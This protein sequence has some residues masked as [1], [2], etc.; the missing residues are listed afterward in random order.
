MHCGDGR[1][2]LTLAHAEPQQ[3]VLPLFLEGARLNLQ[4][5]E[6]CLEWAA[7]VE[8]LPHYGDSARG[9]AGHS[10]G[11]ARVP[12]PGHRLPFGVV[13]DSAQLRVRQRDELLGWQKQVQNGRNGAC[14]GL[15]D[16]TPLPF[17]HKVSDHVGVSTAPC[18]TIGKRR[19]CGGLSRAST[20]AVANATVYGE[21][22]LHSSTCC[23]WH[24][25]MPHWHGGE[26]VDV[27]RFA[28]LVAARAFAL[29]GL[30]LGPS[31][32]AEHARED[33]P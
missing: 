22:W 7:V 4:S 32:D 20:I 29:R 19:A 24:G 15:R 8:Q 33:C 10:S 18:R 13:V 12:S 31:D 2:R 6:L 3:V 21:V 17:G 23:G 14:K 30:V 1:S 26:P 16:M 9:L 5:L 11:T 28:W 25:R 27:S